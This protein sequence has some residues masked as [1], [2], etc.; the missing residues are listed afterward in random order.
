MPKKEDAALTE[1]RKKMSS[2]YKKLNAGK[3]DAAQ[4]EKYTELIYRLTNLNELTEEFYTKGED[5]EYPKVD[6]L[7]LKAIRSSYKS[8]IDICDEISSGI[9]GIVSDKIKDITGELKN[10]MLQDYAALNSVKA[11]DNRTL[12]EIITEGRSLEFDAGNQKMGFVAGSLNKRIPLKIKGTDKEG[13]FTPTTNVD[14]EGRK[15]KIFD[16]ASSKHPELKPLFDKM[17]MLDKN[18]LS[19]LSKVDLSSLIN[20]CKLRTDYKKPLETLEDAKAG[21]EFVLKDMIKKSGVDNALV[22][23]MSKEQNFLRAWLEIQH[24]IETTVDLETTY[25]TSTNVPLNIAPDGNIDK[26]NSAMSE[27]ADL[28]GCSDVIANSKPMIIYSNGKAISGTFMDK[29][30]GYN[31]YDYSTPNNPIDSIYTSGIDNPKVIKQLA[32]LQALDIIC[33]NV[34]RHLGNFMF[35]F[36][37]EGKDLKLV[38]I[39]GI[40]ND[41]S[42]GLASPGTNRGIKNLPAISDMRVI[43]KDMADKIL[44]MDPEVLKA[45]LKGYDLGKSEIDAAVERL[46]LL[47][48]A[49]EAGKNH[50]KDKPEGELEDGFIRVV[51][52]NN[53]GQYKLDKLAKNFN[54]FDNVKNVKTARNMQRPINFRTK[55]DENDN[56][57]T[58]KEIFGEP[59]SAVDDNNGLAIEVAPRKAGVDYN[60][61]Y[62]KDENHAEVE[63]VIGADK[64]EPDKVDEPEPKVSENT[65]NEPEHE[66]TGNINTKAVNGAKKI[67]S[68]KRDTALK[69]GDYD[70]D[71]VYEYLQTLRASADDARGMF[72]D[73]KYYND[74]VKAI[75][76]LT[77]TV[78]DIKKKSEKNLINQVD[79][80]KALKKGVKNLKDAATAY[81]EYKTGD[82]TKNPKAKTKDELNRDDIKKLRLMNR[83]K[84]TVKFFKVDDVPD[85]EAESIFENEISDEEF[86]KKSDEALARLE[87]HKYGTMEA[88]LQDSGLALFGQ[89]H[90]L[91]GNKLHHDPKTG[92]VVSL[93]QLLRNKKESGE[94]RL[95]LTIPNE[96]P[97]VM[98]PS[99]VA[100]LAKD[101]TRMKG[102]IEKLRVQNAGQMLNRTVK[103]ISHEN[104]KTDKNKTKNIIK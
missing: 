69:L 8:V 73:S 48:D 34:D 39:K 40:D 83:V 32:D 84:N 41:M 27:M 88:Y 67:K 62:D 56:I 43:S 3:E 64:K 36:E 54:Y 16:T 1:L 79:A 78:T 15:K 12:G 26:R 101:E 98:G 46:N 89:M 100:A 21:A 61:G 76:K 66:K 29:A 42:F 6:E 60:L 68:Q 20:R 5:G 13:Y 72:R 19:E 30:S 85:W 74:F 93:W 99:K 82:K 103:K 86:L 4:S 44:L 31:A 50:Y 52:E 9:G 10:L 2:I 18:S 81:E 11:D 75:D 63:K 24:D 102:F 58:E 104:L 25:V 92:E 87:N 57:E 90:R 45:S 17:K 38:S 94:L 55:K 14:F 53:W 91:S 47:K 80:F 28:F 96:A 51:D 65:I 59:V 71:Q 37:G 77:N 70:V 7:S 97:K 33:G 49:I 23:K 35:Q 95:A 22:E